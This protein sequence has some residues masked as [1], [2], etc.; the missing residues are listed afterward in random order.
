M[1]KDNECA[2]AEKQYELSLNEYQNRAVKTAT[3]PNI[4]HNL[5]YP[6]FGLASEA[7][8]FC[9]H[10]KKVAR[11]DDNPEYR[12]PV[13]TNA[14]KLALLKELGDTLWYVAVCAFEL[15]YTLEDVAVI[16]NFKLKN[17]ADHGVLNGPKGDDEQRGENASGLD[18]PTCFSCGDLMIPNS[19]PECEGTFLCRNC[20]QKSGTS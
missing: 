2:P 4:G 1:T 17:R 15:G 5:V 11:D 13:I 19:D 18:V 12:V 14:R 3:Y 8:E 6:A 9:G 10:M 20:G 7:G 16:N